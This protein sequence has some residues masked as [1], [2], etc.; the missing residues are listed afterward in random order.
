MSSKLRYERGSSPRVRGKLAGR[1]ELGGDLGLIPACAG[2]TPS[3]PSASPGTRAHPRVCGENMP[4]VG[5][6][7]GKTGSSPRVRGK[8]IPPEEQVSGDRL[9][10]ACAGKTRWRP[11]APT[12]AT[13]HPRVCGE[14]GR[15]GGTPGRPSGSSPRVRGKLG[16]REGGEV[17][18]GLIPACAGKTRRHAAASD[19]A[20][21]H[22][23]VCGENRRGTSSPLSG[24]GSSPR[25][26]GKLLV[27]RVAQHHRGSSPR[28]RGKPAHRR[29]R[30][31]R[32]G[33]IPACAGKT[34]RLHWTTPPRRAHP[35]VCGEN[36]VSVR[37]VLGYPGSSPRVRGKHE[38]EC[39]PERRPGLIPACAG[40][41]RTRGSASRSCQAHPRVCG[42][43][44]SYAVTR[45]HMVGSSPRVRGKLAG[46]LPRAADGGLIPACAGKTPS[47][48]PPH[49]S[50]WAHPRVCG[51]NREV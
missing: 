32:G 44:A 11:W 40:K 49:P 6:D 2:K 35:R 46:M 3:P 28:V 50:R 26:R 19:R 27:V 29:D 25:V 7:A 4:G 42:E 12:R 41:T 13:A 8:R 36:H 45:P 39:S 43:N 31:R 21:A 10:P 30:G 51:E 34:D 5:Q 20:R 22:P 16:E 1:P 38:E 24:C 33:L 15:M 23:R 37:V 14:N 17:G 48:P 9:I 47:W 18:P